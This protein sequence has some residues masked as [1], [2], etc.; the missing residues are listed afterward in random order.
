MRS[1]FQHKD[2]SNSSNF[3]WPDGTFT[4]HKLRYY[5]ASLLAFTR[6]STA[7]AQELLKNVSGFFAENLN[8]QGAIE[9]LSEDRHN[10]RNVKKNFTEYMPF[11]L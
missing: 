8:I 10:R 4:Q 9:T 5:W 11:E 1:R 6:K 2:I 3:D 7:Q